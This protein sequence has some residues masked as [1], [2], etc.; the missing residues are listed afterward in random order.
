[1][2]PP[3]LDRDTFVTWASTALLSSTFACY[4]R[5]LADGQDGE[6][7]IR[8]SDDWGMAPADARYAAETARS[9]LAHF[10]LRR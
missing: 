8:V 2:I 9:W 1:M 10:G 4:V 3:E 7:F 5:S 6:E